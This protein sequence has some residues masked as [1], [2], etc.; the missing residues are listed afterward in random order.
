MPR[1]SKAKYSGKQK[2][3]ARHI[4]EGY[5]SRGV[6]EREAARRAWATVNKE[7]GGGSRGGSGG[8]T[9]R[10]R[11]PSR[12]GGRTGGRA[13]G[14]KGPRAGGRA[15]PASHVGGRRSSGRSRR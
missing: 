4:E 8:R 6:G 9:M 14:R 1:G 5:E 2:R 11:S 3:Q 12:T 10:N 7:W 15:A 13:T